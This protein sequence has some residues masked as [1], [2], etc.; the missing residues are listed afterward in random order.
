MERDRGLRIRHEYFASEAS[1][2]A[3]LQV[4]RRHARRVVADS[5]PNQRGTPLV[6][7]VRGARVVQQRRRREQRDDRNPVHGH[8]ELGTS[9]PHGVRKTRSLDLL[10]LFL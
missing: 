7:R 8:A 9:R 6:G 10:A 1:R 4:V 3:A 5:S 2:D